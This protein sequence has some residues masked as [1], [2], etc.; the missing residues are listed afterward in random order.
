MRIGALRLSGGSGAARVIVRSTRCGDPATRTRTHTACSTAEE[1]TALEVTELDREDVAE[2]GSALLALQRL[3]YAVEARLIGDDRIPT[4]HESESELIA[5]EHD[6]SVVLD[7]SGSPL[8]AIAYRVSG[9]TVEI[10]RLMVHPD[11]HR[12]G[13]G[14][15]LVRHVL[16][17]APRAEVSTGRENAPARRLYEA[18]GFAF[19]EDLE[20]LPGLWVS[21]YRR[22]DA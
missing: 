15:L 19:M 12:R 6:W 11:A 14:R 8:G 13:I 1:A 17:K 22:D 7:P 5:A 3:A 10:D 18:L 21:C 9:G 16:S 4:L 2:L 20:A